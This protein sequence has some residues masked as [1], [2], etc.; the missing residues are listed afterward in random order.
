[1]KR[2][3]DPLEAEFEWKPS[4][5]DVDRLRSGMKQFER[6]NIN[7]RWWYPFEQFCYS[8][9]FIKPGPEGQMVVCDAENWKKQL[10]VYDL[11]KWISLQDLESFHAASPEEK[12]KY[13]K[14]IEGIRAEIRT[15][16][17]IVKV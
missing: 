17:G 9:G 8:L 5:I 3:K 11:H 15:L 1:M 12:V 7:G 14:K 10:A 6:K 2:V 13:D 16:L 4:K